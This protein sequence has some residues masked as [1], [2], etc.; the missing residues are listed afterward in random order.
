MRWAVYVAHIGE[1]KYRVLM[2]ALEQ[3]RPLGIPRHR[4]KDNITIDLKELR[5]GGGTT[6]LI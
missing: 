2:G 1:E 3:R 4:W 6:G 5:W